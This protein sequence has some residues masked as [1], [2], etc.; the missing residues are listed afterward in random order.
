M[1]D[2]RTFPDASVGELCNEQ[3]INV[4]MDMERGGID[5]ARAYNIR[6]IPP[7]R[8]IDPAGRVVHPGGRFS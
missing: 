4:Q 1:M 2:R 8:F 3:F 5:L 6:H 7:Y